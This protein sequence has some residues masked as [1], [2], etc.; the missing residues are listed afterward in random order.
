MI[1]TVPCRDK[2]IDHSFVLSEKLECPLVSKLGWD[3]YLISPMR[4][5]SAVMD[6]LDRSYI[7]LHSIWLQNK[8]SIQISL[9]Y[10]GIEML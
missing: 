9:Y 7:G 5:V 3:I 6:S 8:M 4:Y 1:E 10:R 2:I